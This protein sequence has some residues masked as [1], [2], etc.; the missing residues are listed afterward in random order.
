M[1]PHDIRPLLVCK[2]Q[3]RAGT[4][5]GEFK[6]Q[7]ES[8]KVGAQQVYRAPRLHRHT[9]SDADSVLYSDK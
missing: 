3:E 2:A 8:R 5:L 9:A 7:H 1:G 6:K 4:F